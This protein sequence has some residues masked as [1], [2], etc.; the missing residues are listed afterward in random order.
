MDPGPFLNKILARYYKLELDMQD[1]MAIP[2]N[3]SPHLNH[4]I[5]PYNN[6]IK[7]AGPRRRPNTCCSGHYDMSTRCC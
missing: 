3:L 2:P 7:S 1:K 6:F 4:L 5:D